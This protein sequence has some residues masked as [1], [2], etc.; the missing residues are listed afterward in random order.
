MRDLSVLIPARNEEWLGHTVRDVL[1]HIKADTEIIVVLDG[2]W[3]KVPLEQHQRLKVVYLPQ[4]IGQRAATNL[5]ARLSTARYVMKLDAHCAVDDGF[6]QK[7]L[8]AAKELGDDVTQIPVQYNLHVFDRICVCGKREYQGPTDVPCVACGQTDWKKEVVWNPI[9]RKTDSWRFDGDL[10][11]GYFGE[12]SHRPEAQGDFADVMSCL[13][14]CWFIN[15]ARYW[16]LGGLDEDHG[17]WGQ[18]GTELACMSWLSGGRMVVNRR[19][20]FSHMF[21]TQGHDFGFPYPLRGGEVDHARKY[22]QA[23]WRGGQW[24]HQVRSLRWLVDKFWPIPEWTDAQRAAL[25]DDDTDGIPEPKPGLLTRGVLYYSDCRPSADILEASRRTIE[26]SGMPIMAVTLWPIEWR[27]ARNIVLERWPGYLTMF[28]Q[29]LAGL[30]ALDTDIVFFCEH[31]VLYHPSHFDFMPSDLS[32]VYYNQNIW[33]VDATNGRALHYRCSQ[34]SGLCGSRDVLVEHYRKRVAIVER[35]GFSRS[36]GFEPGT[37]RR[38]ERVDDLTSDIWMSASPNI[39]IRHNTNLT[40]SRWRR[41]QF[42][43]QKYTE[44]WTEADAVPGWGTTRGRMADFL[45]EVSG[46]VQQAVA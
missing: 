23:K 4:A 44:G 31:D 36:M 45:S 41:D 38:P 13:G 6:D 22:S 42:R 7:L 11:F 30:E 35:S 27:S 25:K 34:T 17:S 21:R 1:S 28:R 46:A 18:M 39:D 26:A 5:A 32:K 40:P 15:R 2:E 10:K 3:P 8:E 43:N 16:A 9:R 37:H 24:E 14:A 12:W 20:W 29:I 19:T 33:K